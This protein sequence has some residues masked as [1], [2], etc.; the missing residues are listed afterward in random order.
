MIDFTRVSAAN[1]QR[2]AQ[3]MALAS[4]QAE[5]KTEDDEKLVKGEA[6]TEAETA[7]PESDEA[8]GAETVAAADQSAESQTVN[9]Q[10]EEKIES[11]GS[12]NA[13]A[14][15]TTDSSS[16]AGG[17]GTPEDIQQRL[18]EMLSPDDPDFVGLSRSLQLRSHLGEQTGSLLAEAIRDRGATPNVKGRDS[19]QRGDMKSATSAA[20]NKPA[21]KFYVP[22]T[23]VTLQD[24]GIL[25]GRYTEPNPEA[26]QRGAV[27]FER[28]DGVKFTSGNSLVYQS[29]R[30]KGDEEEPSVDSI[31]L[32]RQPSRAS[33]HNSRMD[34]QSVDWSLRRPGGVQPELSR[35]SS[36]TSPV[37]SPSNSTSGASIVASSSAV[38]AESNTAKDMK[39]VASTCANVSDPETDSKPESKSEEATKMEQRPLGPVNISMIC[40]CG[41]NPSWSWYSKS[42][43]VSL[44]RDSTTVQVRMMSSTGADRIPV[45]VIARSRQVFPAAG[46]FSIDLDFE[47]RN[48]LAYG[49]AVSNSV[50]YDQSLLSAE[51][52]CWVMTSNQM[53]YT[54]EKMYVNCHNIPCA[55]V[56]LYVDM[57]TGL[58]YA[59]DRRNSSN[60]CFVFPALFDR[61]KQLCLVVEL[62]SQDHCTMSNFRAYP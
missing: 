39:V 53:C 36:S 54:P 40:F 24:I 12:G 3:E 50:I 1:A 42:R 62:C 6:K 44:H 32:S 16:T 28:W 18:R 58:M 43:A 41:P 29:E 26:V 22:E 49:L 14:D 47:C 52:T 46:K 21:P 48:R 35:S 56:R 23:T 8:I 10:G 25:V 59:K 33:R 37:I 61:T 2:L 30:S 55:S 19:N 17:S 38:I 9:R 34:F 57:N 31:R 51:Q 7:K 4:E 5:T 15:A 45:R 20:S 27:V 11:T 13:A 60:H